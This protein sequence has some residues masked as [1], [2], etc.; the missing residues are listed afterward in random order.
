[1]VDNREVK[2]RFTVDGADAKK[3]ADDLGKSVTEAGR[4]AEKASSGVRSF[5][6][7]IITANQAAELASKAV[8]LVGESF[9]AVIS[10]IGNG[11][12][13]LD[14]EEGFRKLSGA[15]EE[16]ANILTQQMQDALG[17][18]V[19]KM[20]L[21]GEA[22]R[23]L[24]A[25]LTP[26]QFILAEKA[27][28]SYADTMGGDALQALNSLSDALVR[29]NDRALKNMGIIVD[30]N[31]A[32]RDYAAANGVAA[33]T[34]NEVGQAEAIRAAALE[35]L[36]AKQKE[37]GDVQDDA[38]DQ[39]DKI[40]AAMKNAGNEIAKGIAS[41]EA[42]NQALKTLANTI[43]SV[44][45]KPIVEGVSTAV[46]KIV[47]L[48]NV[49][50][51]AA[52]QQFE[53]FIQVIGDVGAATLRF[54][55]DSIPTLISGIE[56]LSNSLQV[57]GALREQL[58]SGSLPSL[59][60]A[61]DTVA[62]NQQAAG[63]EKLN[64]AQKRLIETTSKARSDL[65]DNIFDQ[66]IDSAKANQTLQQIDKLK[67]SYASLGGDTSKFSGFKDVEEQLQKI[68]ATASA[69]VP[70]INKTNQVITDQDKVAKKAADALKK[71]EEA[72]K[73]KA[74]ADK[75]AAEAIKKHNEELLKQ[76]QVIADLVTSSE[77]YEDI[78]KKVGK[79]TLDSGTAAKQ[80]GALFLDASTKQKEFTASSN[81]L[82]EAL[83]SLGQGGDV[84]TDRIGDLLLK[85]GEASKQLEGLGDVAKENSGFLDD[86]LGSMFGDAGSVDTSSFAASL[87]SSLTGALG[88]VLST[89]ASDASTVD[90]AKNV[91]ATIGGVL[92]TAVGAYFG[93]PAGAA[94]GGT[95]GSIGGSAIGGLFAH[96]KTEGTL[97]RKK[98]DEY[99]SDLFDAN[100]LS[101]IINDQLVTLDELVMQG[102]FFSKGIGFTSDSPGG[103]L[104]GNLAS[105]PA[106]VQGAFN[107]VGT[108]FENL[109]GVSDKIGGQI[110]AILAN[111]IGGSLNNLQLLVQATGKSLEEMKE[112]VVDSF[113]DAQ[114][115]A[116]EAQTALNGLQE[117]YT[118]GIPGAIGATTEA[119]NNLVASAGR[120]R[121]AFDAVGDLGAEGLEKG[122]TSLSQ[123]QAD[124][125]ASGKVSAEDV[126]K[127][128]S[129]ISAAGITSLEALKDVTAETAIG[130]LANLEAGGFAFQDQIDTIDSLQAKLDAIQDKETTVKINVQTNF[131]SNTQEFVNSGL[132]QTAYGTDSPGNL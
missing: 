98:V 38:K 81:E 117:I 16:T 41:N 10:A 124:L 5:S 109:L 50:I 126:Q 37:L 21:L 128:F 72:A 23:V 13:L 95:L 4:D 51:P 55:R 58:A 42:L 61:I 15:S 69:I 97:A 45:F 110:A 111:N 12:D 56:N 32:L 113:L 102:G 25:G 48:A 9:T 130:I 6:D 54:A 2:I 125:A 79:G 22:N 19:D 33:D 99:F 27:A 89:L 87:G 31:K 77:K 8:G 121:A 112:A 28:R 85:F 92:G 34:L 108:A 40:S 52:I 24:A 7:S 36:A 118:A 103:G 39:L 86:L 14:L 90:K 123:L 78:L 47:E 60:G 49:A 66:G 91:G 59:S 80:L 62:F 70:P 88:N 46:T 76:Q 106:D 11:A 3:T 71:A 65:F 122:Y 93:G 84:S 82:N 63:I 18:T 68:G 127:L 132:A 30:N 57:V 100:R 115:G 131:D 107:G 105:L 43:L 116:L 20:T 129:A 114:I 64:E 96:K 83:L 17:G 44:D 26:E 29:G 53:P 35:A 104:F 94:I 119:L 67:A 101:I 120:G 74:D 73:K 75:K 1:M